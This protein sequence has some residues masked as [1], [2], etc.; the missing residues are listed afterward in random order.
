MN[1][2][3]SLC[4]EGTAGVYGSP[5]RSCL[6]FRLELHNQSSRRVGVHVVTT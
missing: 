4:I 1:L 5:P 6:E 3:P 2:D